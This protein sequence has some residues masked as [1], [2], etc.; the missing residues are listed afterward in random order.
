MASQDPWLPRPVSFRPISRPSNVMSNLLVADLIN[1]SNSSPGWNTQLLYRCRDYLEHSDVQQVL[2]LGAQMVAVSMEFIHSSKGEDFYLEDFCRRC[3]EAREML[4]IDCCGEVWYILAG[5]NSQV[6]ISSMAN[7]EVFEKVL[8]ETDVTQK[9]SVPI[10]WV[11]GERRFLPTPIPGGPVVLPVRDQ[12]GNDTIL[13]LAVR[14]PTEGQKSY[15]M[16]PVFMFKEWS[17]LVAS[18]N[19]KKGE[20]A[21]FWWEGGYLRI[22]VRAPPRLKSALHLDHV[23]RC[24][25]RCPHQR[26][27]TLSLQHSAF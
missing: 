10:H 27:T 21:Y 15:H 2:R 14:S 20:S 19:L 7:V 25:H 16:K 12:N 8:S 5:Y 26:L 24:L 22:K 23:I 4:L 18:F 9:M 11:E 6:I 3:S 1:P 17:A 13:R